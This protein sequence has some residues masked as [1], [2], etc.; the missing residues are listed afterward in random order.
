MFIEVCGDALDEFGKNFISVLAQNKRLTLLPSIAE[1]FETFKANREKRVDVEVST[2]Y[3]L[4]QDSYATLSLLGIAYGNEGAH[5]EAI[6]YFEL[7]ILQDPK[8]A[9]AYLHLGTAFKNL[10]D[11]ENAEINLRKA[12]ELDPTILNN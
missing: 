9:R 4:N 3:E 12:Q 10:G 8:I 2:A 6:K 7:A 11:L 5:E 1:L